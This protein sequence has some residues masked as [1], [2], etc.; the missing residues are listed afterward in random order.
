MAAR[1]PSASCARSRRRP[2]STGDAESRISPASS[3]VS[4]SRRAS[5]GWASTAAARASSLG[6][7][8]AAPRRGV[9]QGAIDEAIDEAPHALGDDAQLGDGPDLLGPEHEASF[10]GREQL[11]DLGHAQARQRLAPAQDRRELVDG[12]HVPPRLGGVVM[13]RQREARRAPRLRLRARRE[14]REEGRPVEG[15]ARQ[16]GDVH[17]GA[18]L[19]RGLAGGD[20]PRSSRAV[21]DGVA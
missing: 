21:T 18:T 9:V 10:G 16:L 2:A 12:R 4:R 15:G 5:A 14:L 20:K 11:V 17:G 3:N 1:A 19:T 13:E 8:R 6:R 7:G